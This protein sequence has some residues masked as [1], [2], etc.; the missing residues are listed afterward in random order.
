VWEIAD[1]DE[2]RSWLRERGFRI[3]FEYD[4]SKGN[5]SE[6][7]SGVYQLVLDPEQWFGFSVHVDVPAPVTPRSRP[8]GPCVKMTRPGIDPAHPAR[9]HTT[10]VP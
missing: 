1:V 7:A 3:R 9:P 2:A 8:A 5:A 4:S 10:E 6:A